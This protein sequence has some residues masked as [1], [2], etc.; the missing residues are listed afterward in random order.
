[1]DKIGSMDKTGMICIEVEITKWI[2][3][4]GIHKCKMT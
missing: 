1:M 2:I 3:T 4:I